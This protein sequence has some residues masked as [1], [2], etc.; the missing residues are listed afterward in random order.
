MFPV[1]FKSRQV[2]QV[3]QTQQCL[4]E[5]ETVSNRQVQMTLLHKR[6]PQKSPEILLCTGG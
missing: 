1:K 2:R 4:P 6:G 3:T 5:E